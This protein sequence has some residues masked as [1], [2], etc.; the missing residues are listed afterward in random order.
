[1]LTSSLPE[2]KN[3]Q[4]SVMSF[5]IRKQILQDVNTVKTGSKSGTGE[6][7]ACK[8]QPDYMHNSNN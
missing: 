7:C 3:A 5:L 8:I 4:H 2:Y 6:L 1:M